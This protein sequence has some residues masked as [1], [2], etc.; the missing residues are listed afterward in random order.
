MSESSIERAIAAA[1]KDVLETSLVL[2][3]SAQRLNEHSTPGDGSK[4]S[5][6]PTTRDNS[7]KV[8]QYATQSPLVANA[9]DNSFKV[10][11]YATQSPL[12][13]SAG[14]GHPSR[15]GTAYG[16]TAFAGLAAAA[17]LQKTI[18]APYAQQRHGWGSKESSTYGG[19]IFAGFALQAHE[20]NKFG[21][22]LGAVIVAA[23]VYLERRIAAAPPPSPLPGTGDLTIDEADT[24][25]MLVATAAVMLMIPALGLFEAG[26][27]RAKNSVSVLMQCFAGLAVLSVLWFVVGF[28]LCFSPVDLGL[29]ADAS[30]HFFLARVDWRTPLPAAPT[31]PGVLFVAFQGMFASITPL[32]CTGAFAERLRFG[33]FLV[34]IV[35]WSFL[36]YYPLCHWVWGGGWLSRLGVV[37]FAGGIVIHTAAGI[38]SL[39]TAMRLGPRSGFTGLVSH[40]LSPHNLPMAATG[41]GLLWFG[42]FAF[43]GGSALTS[44]SLAASTVMATH[45]AGATGTVAWLALDWLVVGRPT[46][47]G[48]INGALSGLAGVTPASGFVTPSAGLVIGL[49][50]A[51]ASY[52]GVHLFKEVLRI[53]DALD[54]SSIHGVTGVVGS[55]LIGVY[56]TTEVNEGGPEASLAQVATQALGVAVAMIWSGAGTHLVMSSA[57]YFMPARIHE[58]EEDRGLDMSQ[59]GE[60]SYLDL[61]ALV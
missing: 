40:A 47:V 54:V 24:V 16:G 36:V 42:W 27:L 34:F 18:T 44:G 29:V 49:L 58:D 26:L 37:D 10:K 5:S 12:V 53:D 60:S 7:F 22:I 30:T 4:L 38:A 2:A 52:G 15:E 59:H 6:A 3:R 35:L 8:K 17:E 21:L 39:V 13:A 50:C 19:S 11:Q 9:G 51:I 61:T 56:A 31:I 32:L 45:I 33:P 43:N 1:E 48:A 55:L 23:V 41:A 25:W 28:S 57:E 14:A 46:F 20:P